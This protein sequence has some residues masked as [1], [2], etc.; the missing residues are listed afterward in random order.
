MEDRGSPNMKT[1]HRNKGLTGLAI[2]LIVLVISPPIRSGMADLLNRIFELS[3]SRNA[4][5]YVRLSGADPAWQIPAVLVLLGL[6]LC[7]FLVLARLSRPLAGTVFLTVLASVQVYFGITLSTAVN[8]LLF[9]L[10]VLCLIRPSVKL[11]DIVF[12]LAV[13]L[14]VFILVGLFLPGTDSGLEQTSEQVRDWFGARFE[15]GGNDGEMPETVVETRHVNERSLDEG[16]REA[17]GTEEY[18]LIQ[19]ERMKIARPDWFSLLRVVLP[20]LGMILLLILPFLPF[21]FLNRRRQKTM[22]RRK[23]FEDPDN[24]IAAMAM[25]RH[26]CRYLQATGHLEANCPYRLCPLPGMNR[27]FEEQFHQAAIVWERAAYSDHPI[28][29]LQRAEIAQLLEETEK[30]LYEQADKR[31]Q[32][33]LRTVECLH[34]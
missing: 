7:L 14:P 27:A 2:V 24:R 15:S 18:R 1:I 30:R 5:R 21:I 13:L 19:L 28:E 12:M 32:F 9:L 31:Q 8:V 3:E 6:F 16:N 22:E 33:R 20:L 17:R 4:Y 10:T 23:P 25:F 29:D 34:L 26:V 11:R